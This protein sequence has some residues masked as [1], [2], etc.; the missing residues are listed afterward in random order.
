MEIIPEKETSDPI[1]LFI[2]EENFSKSPQIAIKLKNKKAVVAILDSGS[3][4]NLISQES[5]EQL[6]DADIEILTL[7]VQGVNLVTA[8]GKGSKRIKL[9]ALLEFTIGEELFEAVFLVAPQLNSDVILGCN[10]MKEHEV[11]LNFGSGIL[12]YKRRG[13][14][15]SHRFENPETD[16]QTKAQCVI[17]KFALAPC[18]KGRHTGEQNSAA[19]TRDIVQASYPRPDKIRGGTAAGR[20]DVTLHSE[21]PLRGPEQQQHDQFDP[22]DLKE[23]DL[24]RIIEQSTTIS[25]P[26][27]SQLFKILIQFLPNF[28]ERPGKCHLFKYHFQVKTDQPLRSFSRPVPFAFRPAVKLQI[29]NMIKDDIL[30]LSNSDVLS[31]L[32]VVP[33]EGKSPRICV[34]ARKV[35]RHTTPD[36]E[37]APPLQELLQRFEGAKFMSSLDL[38]SAYLQV[39]LHEDSRKYTAFLYDSVV[40]QYKRVPYGFKN[41]LPAFMRALRLALGD[42][43]ENFVLT[44]VDDIL[45]YSRTFEEHLDH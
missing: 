18:V 4:V 2:N 27:K 28:T 33:R 22:R 15:R 16:P 45:V 12:E 14:I 40:Y 8:F 44:Y 11:Q 41:S 36:Y 10:F 39:E 24:R 32:T 7:P 19:Y 25:A 23:G 9:Q 21:G 3:E 29:Q 17:T 5:F 26:Q 20:D 30:E 35:N 43:T 13:Q 37:R 31:P 1:V 38:S 6:K 34:D 42:G